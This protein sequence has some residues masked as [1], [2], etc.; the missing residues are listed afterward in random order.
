M[1][2]CTSCLAPIVWAWV[3]NSRMPLDPEPVSFEAAGLVAY[4]PQ[5]Q[6]GRVLTGDDLGHLGAWKAKGVTVHR[7]HFA[8]CPNADR[9]RGPLA[10]QLT[11]EDVLPE[12]HRGGASGVIGLVD[13][14]DVLSPVGAVDHG[15]GTP[16][17]PSE[18]VGAEPVVRYEH[19]AVED[20]GGAVVE[21]AV[22]LGG[23]LFGG[24]GEGGDREGG[25]H[26]LDGR[27]LAP[28]GVGECEV[29]QVGAGGEAG[30]GG[31]LLD[32][33]LL[34][35]SDPEGDGLVA[36]GGH[37]VSV[38]DVYTSVLQW[39]AQRKTDRLGACD[40]SPVLDMEVGPGP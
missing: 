34:G 26:R 21:A 31:G 2:D 30:F 12:P 1:S 28:G 11:I 14:F 9:H 20:V 16:D 15:E 6:T 38:A 39:V 8:T 18:S 40:T 36:L 19:H 23:Q 32:G 10:G 5:R 27:G 25:A 24:V 3:G 37:W 13:P 17:A 35:G 7:S 33:A 22:E 4:N 29:A